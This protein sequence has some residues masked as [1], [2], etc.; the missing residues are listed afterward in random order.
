MLCCSHRAVGTR[1]HHSCRPLPT[2]KAILMDRRA[3]KAE[4][5]LLYDDPMRTGSASLKQI[6]WKYVSPGP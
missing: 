6:T 2:Q 5:R 4:V 1:M 3:V